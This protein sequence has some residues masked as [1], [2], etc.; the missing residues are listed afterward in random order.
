M[1]ERMSTAWVNITR[2]VQT[3][4]KWLGYVLTAGAGLYL[5][6]LLIISGK[7]FREIPL[8]DFWQAIIVTLFLYLASL[9]VQFFIWVRVISFHHRV[10]WQDVAI[11]ARVILL[12]RLPGGVWHW[13]GRTTMYA[14]AAQLPAKT[15]MLA[16]FLEW[17]LLILVALSITIAGLDNL[18]PWLRV[19]LSAFILGLCVWLVWNWQPN[20]RKKRWRLGEGLLWTILYG[21]A[22]VLGGIIVF[23]FAQ[24]AG[25]TALTW[26][27]AVWV[28]AIA[29]GA[30]FFI[31]F[32]PAGLGIR[33]ITIT[34][35]LQPYL[36]TAGALLVAIAIRFIFVLSD[37]LWGGLGWGISAW[38]LKKQDKL[39]PPPPTTKNKKAA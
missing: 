37:L 16:N 10:S 11:Y 18:A 20:S 38:A 13:L 1:L 3:R 5:V 35:L 25:N 24:A 2:H 4:L 34:L 22:W 30:G 15:V 12:R 33:E 17:A 36:P 26:G 8:Q 29:G 9:G 31:V 6:A 27:R 23:I 14:E 32:I 39:Q 7:Q 28:W 19:G 21:L